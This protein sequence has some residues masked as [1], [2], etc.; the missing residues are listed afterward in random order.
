MRPR[1]LPVLSGLLCLVAAAQVPKVPRTPAP[2]PV[3]SYLL[4]LRRS[5]AHPRT[6]I[7][8]IC[9]PD[10]RALHVEQL[11]GSDGPVVGVLDVQGSPR[12]ADGR[13]ARYE[14]R[15]ETKGDRVWLS[16]RLPD[17]ARLRIDRTVDAHRASL[18]LLVLPEGGRGCAEGK[19]AVRASAAGSG[20]TA[21]LTLC[22]AAPMTLT[23]DD[24]APVTAQ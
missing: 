3:E 7:L 4:T 18:S 9:T 1:L 13:L 11:Q 2:V 12:P 6:I 10:T 14:Y 22:A 5:T 19:A 16:V 17:G 21:D 23:W 15:G 20:R 24:T 8:E